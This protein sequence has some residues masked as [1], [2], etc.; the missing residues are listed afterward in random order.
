MPSQMSIV[1]DFS[2]RWTDAIWSASAR[3]RNTMQPHQVKHIYYTILGG[4]VRWSFLFAFLFSNAPQR[5]TAFIA[6]FNNVAIGVTSFQ[7]LWINHRLLPRELRPRWYHSLGVVG[8]GI[9][10][11]GIALLVFVY[12][13]WPMW[14]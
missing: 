7:L 6:N 8:C 9:F 12:K 5:M 13:I 14:T 1:D 4:Y 10:Y 11:L 3:V 2:R